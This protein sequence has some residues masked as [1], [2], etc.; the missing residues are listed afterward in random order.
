MKVKSLKHK[1]QTILT[2]NTMS[3]IGFRKTALSLPIF[4][5][6]HLSMSNDV[7]N[8]E[9]KDET[10]RKGSVLTHKTR[11]KPS[12]RSFIADRSKVEV[13]LLFSFVCF[14]ANLSR[15]LTCELI[16]YPWIRRPSVIRPSSVRPHFRTSSLPKPLG[17]SKPNFMW[18]LLGK[19]ERK[20][21]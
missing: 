9:W 20:F 4:I 10:E 14:L 2:Q 11:L 8:L 15:R 13:L 12:S 17:Q 16:G 5:S 3:L 18:S 1:T 6:T 21:I 19:G 7:Y